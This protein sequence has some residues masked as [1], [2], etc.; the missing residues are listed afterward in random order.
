[1]I[2]SCKN[3]NSINNV[4]TI[5]FDDLLPSFSK[6]HNSMLVKWP[7]FRSE[8][9]YQMPIYSLIGIEWFMFQGIL[10]RAKHMVIWRCKVRRVRIVGQHTPTKLKQ[11]LEGNQTR[12]WSCI[13]LVKHKALIIHEFWP[14][15]IDCIAQFVHLLEIHGRTF[16]WFLDKSSKCTTPLKSHHMTTW[17]FLVNVHL[18]RG[19]RWFIVMFPRPLT[20]DVIVHSL[21]LV[22]S[23]R[24]LQK[25][26]SFFMLMK[27]MLK[28]FTKWISFSS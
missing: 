14:L 3:K 12:V 13:V 1:M 24:T 16:V 18:G 7:I 2:Y 11:F 22:I 19:L 21:F 9:L 6:I 5:L 25:R 8:K 4:L 20:C 10:Q 28:H 26:V 17:P 23:D 27:E 15:L